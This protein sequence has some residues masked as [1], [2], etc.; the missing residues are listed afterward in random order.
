MIF[1]DFRK[2][3]K[4]ITDLVIIKV[5]ELAHIGAPKFLLI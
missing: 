3:D 2:K 4:L 5:A 1:G